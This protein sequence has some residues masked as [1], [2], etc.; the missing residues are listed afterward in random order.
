MN[1]FDME[2][3]VMGG[4]A[5]N[6]RAGIRAAGNDARAARILHLFKGVALQLLRVAKAASGTRFSLFFSKSESRGEP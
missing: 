5:Q 3:S 6:Q 2:A 1:R 4:G